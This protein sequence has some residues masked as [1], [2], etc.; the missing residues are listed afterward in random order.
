MKKIL[1]IIFLILWISS[2]FAYSWKNFDLKS[3]NYFT[4]YS[5]VSVQ[6]KWF[7]YNIDKLEFFIWWI[8]FLKFRSNVNAGKY[9]FVVPNMVALNPIDLVMKF[10]VYRDNYHIEKDYPLSMTFPYLSKI[11][12]SWDKLIINWNIPTTWCKLQILSWGRLNISWNQ[13][14][15]TWNSNSIKVYLDCDWLKSNL[16]SVIRQVRQTKIDTNLTWGNQQIKEKA[17]SKKIII[18]KKETQNIKT[19]SKT[20]K[21]KVLTKQE[22]I[23]Q[24]LSLINMQKLNRLLGVYLLKKVKKYKNNKVKLWYLKQMYDDYL[25]MVMFSSDSFGMKIKYVDVLIDF[26]KIY[27]KFIK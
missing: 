21:K 18:K 17:V 26:A 6:T 2:S 12:F 15:Y 11:N 24:K 9:I 22:K 1:F 10:K 25:K 4:W 27:F 3:E 23:A 16:I 7:N 19:V 13:S 20:Q 5:R 8:R 14:V